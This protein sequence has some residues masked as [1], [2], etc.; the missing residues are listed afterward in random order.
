VNL[1]NLSYEQ[2]KGWKVTK[3]GNRH[4][5]QPVIEQ[6]SPRGDKIYWI[7]A[8]GE[9]KIASEGTDFYAI[10]QGYVSI[11]P[12]QLNLSDEDRRLKMAQST[13]NKG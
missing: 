13:W 10:N 6:Q 4:P 8:A 3:L 9:A 5:S 11:T 1:P 7:G 12:L 2:F